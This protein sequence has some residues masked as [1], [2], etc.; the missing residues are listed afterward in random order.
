M[1]AVSGRADARAVALPGGKLGLVCGST[2][3]VRVDAA[4]LAAETFVGIPTAARTGCAAAVTSRHLVIAGGMS[5]TGVE[6]TVEVY[7]AATLAP[8]AS[9]TLAVPRHDAIAIVLANDQVLIAGGLDADGQP[10]ATLELFTPAN[11]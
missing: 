11:P 1:T 10:T 2:E 7:D 9:G 8:V 3:L 4:T 6:G 5:A